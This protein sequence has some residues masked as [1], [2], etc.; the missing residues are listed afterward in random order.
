MEV[1]ARS[2]CKKSLQGV[3]ARS[4]CKESHCKESLQG[5]IARSHESHCKLQVH[6]AKRKF[7]S[8]WSQVQVASARS[9]VQ[10]ASA[11]SQVQLKSLL[12]AAGS[13][14]DTL[15]KLTLCRDWRGRGA[16]SRVFFLR[17]CLGPRDPL[18]GS[19]WSR[20]KN[21]VFFCDFCGARA[22]F[23]ADRRGRGTKT[24][25]DLRISAALARPSAGIG[26]VEVQKKLE[27]FCDFCGARATLCGDRRGRGA[28]TRGFL[29]LLLFELV[30]LVFRAP[31][32]GTGGSRVRFLPGPRAGVA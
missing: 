9:Q 25:G 21:S 8:A 10:V 22:T 15:R 12:R 31:A 19:A 20:C 29:R 2:Y 7:A 14:D 23:C 3:I 13:A 18:R 6:G 11:R 26:V 27:V 30:L 32:P 4:H 5:V 24:R 17:F 28:K 16:K 1:I